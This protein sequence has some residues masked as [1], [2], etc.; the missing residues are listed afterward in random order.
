MHD[1]ALKSSKL[2]SKNRSDKHA[3]DIEH[4][5]HKEHL[6]FHPMTNHNTKFSLI[7]KMTEQSKS[8]LREPSPIS[9]VRPLAMNHKHLE[10]ERLHRYNSGLQGKL[11]AQ[12][13][14]PAYLSN[15]SNPQSAS[16]SKKVSTISSPSPTKKVVKPGSHQK[17]S[18]PPKPILNQTSPS[19]GPIQPYKP[20][21]EVEDEH[22]SSDEEDKQRE[23]EPIIFVDVAI[24]KSQEPVRIAIYNDSDPV[25]LA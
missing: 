14:I 2:I 24:S 21:N 23:D 9:P 1:K 3:H 17:K 12:E 15:L 4:E 18:L 5:K 6:T 10:K 22:F 19:N 13:Y 7:P 8:P 11:S 25:K 20:V 16:P